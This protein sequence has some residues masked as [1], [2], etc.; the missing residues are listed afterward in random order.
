MMQ[1]NLR[2]IAVL[3]FTLG[4]I[5]ND[6]F[7]FSGISVQPAYADIFGMSH[8]DLARDRDFQRAVLRVVNGNCYVSEG[9]EQVY[10]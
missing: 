8:Q 6:V 10:C 5:A 4:Y 3:A 1:R 9:D 7:E 2:L